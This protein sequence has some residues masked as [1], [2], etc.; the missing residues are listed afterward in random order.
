L[1][2]IERLRILI[3]KVKQLLVKIELSHQNI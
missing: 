2:G 3:L 1:S